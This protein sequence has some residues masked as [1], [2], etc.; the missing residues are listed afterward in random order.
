MYISGTHNF[1]QRFVT[2]HVVVLRRWC[3]PEYA[4]SIATLATYHPIRVPG[5]YCY[6]HHEA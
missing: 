4:A 5:V 1:G 6:S 3:E 2:W